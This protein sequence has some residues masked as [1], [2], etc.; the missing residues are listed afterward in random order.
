MTDVPLRGKRLLLRLDLNVPLENGRIR[1]E[2]R[3]R[4]VLPTVRRALD[5]G[6]AL[7]LMSHLGRPRAGAPAMDN[8]RYSLRPVA[9]RMAELLGRELPLVEDWLENAPEVAPGE[10]VLLENVRFLEGETRNSQA[11]GRRMA[12]LCDVFVMDAFAVAHRAHASTCA[13]AAQAPLACA[14]PLL[15]HELQVLSQA[16]EGGPQ[17]SRRVMAVVGGAKVGTK[18]RLLQNLACKVDHLAVGGGIANTFLAAVGRP[19]G[20]SLYEPE[21]LSTAREIAALGSLVLPRDVVVARTADRDGAAYPRAVEAVTAEEAIFDLGPR[22]TAHIAELLQQVDTVVWNGPLGMF[23][24][25]RF[26]TGTGALAAALAASPAFTIAGGG[27]T[28]AAVEHFGVA[29]RIDFLSTGGGA[30]LHCLEGG[31]LPAVAAL[32]GASGPARG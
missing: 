19:V 3:M 17:S 16:L 28:L 31:E 10:A 27:D 29:E 13:V 30:F 8:A 32:R 18:L 14:G 15:L 12:A 22:S 26:A 5:E 9:Q 25:A 20:A 2:A 6:A 11:L 24:D 1:S 21:L 4:A 23:E 7:L